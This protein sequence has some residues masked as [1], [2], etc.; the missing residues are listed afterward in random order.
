MHTRFHSKPKLETTPSAPALPFLL[1]PQQLQVVPSGL[2]PETLWLLAIRSDQL[3]YETSCWPLQLL[4]QGFRLPSL[5]THRK[6][7]HH[8]QP[9]RAAKRADLGSSAGN[10]APFPWLQT[11]LPQSTRDNSG[12]KTCSPT[13]SQLKHFSATGTRT[14]VARMRAEVAKDAR[15]GVTGEGL[16][17]RAAVQGRESWQKPPMGFEFMTSRPLSECSDN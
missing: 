1:P 7:A 13:P 11:L 14:R 5:F 2:E 8:S 9:A 10:C 15:V 12:G 6:S 3:S 17:T 4:G 16:S